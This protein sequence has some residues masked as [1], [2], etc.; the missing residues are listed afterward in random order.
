MALETASKRDFGPLLKEVD[1]A[2]A[3]MI[4]N[5]SDADAKVQEAIA[6]F[7]TLVVEVL[8]G[9]TLRALPDLGGRVFGLRVGVEGSAFAKLPTGRACIVLEAKGQLVLATAFSATSGHVQ[10]LPKHFVR[11][12]LLVPYLRAAN[13]ALEIHV[14]AAKERGAEFRR[15]ADLAERVKGFVGKELSH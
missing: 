3:A 8:R 9:E 10:K 7:E 6:A 2:T 12:S 4:G 14:G 15:V 11:A 1:E 13:L 5:R